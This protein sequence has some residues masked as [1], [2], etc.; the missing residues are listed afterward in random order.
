MSANITCD[1]K[2]QR[3]VWKRRL[4]LKRE[5]KERKE[6]EKRKRREKGE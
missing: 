2:E 4:R 3:E 1:M 6:G 5:E